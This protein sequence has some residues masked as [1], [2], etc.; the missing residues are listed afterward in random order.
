M[1]ELVPFGS[2]HYF[3]MLAF[4]TFGR[5]MDFLS[6]WV[7]TPNLVS[8]G[9]PLSRKLGWKWAIPLNV[10]IC[11]GLA[12]WP[13]PAISISTIGVLVASRNFQEAWLMR[14]LG[15]ETYRDWKL[16]RIRETR[17]SLYLLCLFGQTALIASVGAA[18]IY[19]NTRQ[20]VPVAIGLGI[21]S[22]AAMAFFL[23]LLCVRHLLRM[24]E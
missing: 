16:A 13:L 2:R 10:L 22:Y 24:P 15:E 3:L 19:F 17:P 9:N 12:V 23:P 14:S 1:E 21:I 6:T 11:L 20:L 18:L 7:A 8:E 5:G 4:M